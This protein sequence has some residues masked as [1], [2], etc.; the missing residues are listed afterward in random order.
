MSRLALA[1]PWILSLVTGCRP[2]VG[3]EPV[4]APPVA[5]PATADP[6]LDGMG[7]MMLSPV[8]VDVM[9]PAAIVQHLGLRADSIVADV[10]AGPGAFT[11]LLARAVPRGRVIATDVS[12]PYLAHIEGE[13]RAQGEHHVEARLV[14]PDA[15][16]LADHEVDVVFLCQVDHYLRDRRTYLAALARALRP[17]GRIVIVNYLRERDAIEAVMRELGWTEVDRWQPVE[18]FFARAYRP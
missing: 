15:T 6:T 17:E 3:Q 2:R 12:G 14:A 16:G 9:Q 7:R 8:R 4:A 5:K 11:H 18:G 10:G 1:A 13:A